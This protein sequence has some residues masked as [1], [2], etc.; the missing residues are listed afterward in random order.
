MHR[1]ETIDDSTDGR[2]EGDL[3][4]VSKAGDVGTD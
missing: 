4:G 3:G 1:V 2:R